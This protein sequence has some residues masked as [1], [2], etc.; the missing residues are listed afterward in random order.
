M[1]DPLTMYVS[2]Q[3]SYKLS[4]II[5]SQGM[6]YNI[7]SQIKCIIDSINNGNKVGFSYC[8]RIGELGGTERTHTRLTLF[9]YSLS[10]KNCDATSHEK[11]I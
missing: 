9:L 3:D 2:Q 7:P 4:I 1:W 6:V 10:L 8:P 11:N 5:W